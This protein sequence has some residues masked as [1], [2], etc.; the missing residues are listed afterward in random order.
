MPPRVLFAGIFHETHTFLPGLTRLEDFELRLGQQL[1]AARGDSSPLAGG[2]EVADTAGWQVVPVFDL[3]ATP[4]ATVEDAVVERFCQELQAAAQRE[5][6]AGIDGLFLVLH[7]AMV[8]QSL[9]DVEGEIL[10]RIRHMPG[11]DRVPICGVVDLHANFTARMAERADGLVAYRENPHTDAHAAAVIAAQLLDR[12]LKSGEQPQ[13]LWERPPLMWAPT[14]VGTAN[15]PMRSLEDLARQIESRLPEILSVSVYAGYSFAD[16]PDT[17]VSFTA[18]TIGDPR[19]ARAALQELSALAM[20][21]RQEG[22]KVDT[23]LAE[24]LP[25]LA[26]LREGPVVVVEPSDNIGGGAPGDGTAILR[27]FVDHGIAGAGVVINDPAAVRKVAEAGTRPGQRIT[28]SMGGREN[29]L[30]GPPVTLEVELVSTSDGRFDLEDRH[31]HLASMS[32]VH[33]DMGPCAVV[34]HGGVTVLLTSRKTPPFDLGQWR[35]QGITPEDLR[36]IAVKAA[37]AHRQAYNPIAKASYTV[38]TP[39]P[40]SSNLASLP[41]RKVRRPVFPLD[42]VGK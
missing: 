36:V 2:L 33:I 3:R 42:A 32:G 13:T 34:R 16:T 22:H 37:V 8:S 12:L 38:D 23:P 4:S 10:E 24:V 19:V 11:L 30:A 20:S 28:L 7:G 27:A 26:D 5:A 25:L 21:L 15:V 41:F 40:C 14:G 9:P 29:K 1:L 35:S 31:S 17:G 18:T 6:S 39:G